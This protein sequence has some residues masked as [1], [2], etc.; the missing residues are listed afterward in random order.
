M[1][2][3]LCGLVI[4]LMMTGNGYSREA[5]KDTCK[6]LKVKAVKLIET[7]HAKDFVADKILQKS[8]KILQDPDDISPEGEQDLE[9]ESYKLYKKQ[10]FTY[11]KDAHYYAVTWSALCD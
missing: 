5:S 3:V 10:Q 6:W 11:V 8:D 2:K 4:A 7:A 1:K 9:Y